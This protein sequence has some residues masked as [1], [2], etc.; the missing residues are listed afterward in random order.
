MTTPEPTPLWPSFMTRG[1]LA[2]AGLLACT[3]SIE[4]YPRELEEAYCA[5]QHSCHAFE[6]VR[7]CVAAKVI[8]QDP[9]YDYLVRANAAGSIEYDAHA[10][11]DCLDAIRDRGCT[12]DDEAPEVCDRVFIGK[13]G[14]NAPCLNT[15]ECAGNAVCGFDP[16]CT[17]QCCVGACR[18]FADPVALGESCSFSGTA[19]VPE[20]YCAQDPMTGMPTVCTR[21]VKAGGD[22]SLGQ[23][24]DESSQCDERGKCH[25]VEEVGEGERCD[26]DFVRCAEPASCNYRDG[27]ARCRSRPVHGQPCDPDDGGCEGVDV[28]CDRASLLCT[29]LPGPGQACPEYQCL[30]YARCESVEGGADFD[31]FGNRPQ[32]CV[33]LP[34]E[35]EGCGEY[36]SCLGDL[37]CTDAVCTLPTLEAAPV[38]KVPGPDA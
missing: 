31:E 25:K 9:Q 34:T 38:C 26:V 14:R 17:D 2:L 1:G 5:W 29:L 21:L 28:Y 35:G 20:G 7:D 18:V 24:C 37:Q 27:E 30:P 11:A 22:C 8:D 36:G 3:P 32:T 33:R 19:C 15:A 13:I 23:R 12:D 10:A 4:D 16:A 6:R